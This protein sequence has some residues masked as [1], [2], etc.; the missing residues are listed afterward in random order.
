MCRRSPRQG[1]SAPSRL[2]FHLD[3]PPGSG[4]FAF[5]I[6]RTENCCTNQ[7]GHQDGSIILS[8]CDAE[9]AGALLAATFSGLIS[10]S[11]HAQA[12]ASVNYRIRIGSACAHADGNGF[13]IQL[14]TVPLDGRVA[15]RIATEKNK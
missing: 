4:S 15:L 6:S 12:S 9:C 5:R 13:N 11:R 8:V 10:T 14:G 3:P 1:R 2:G 7:E